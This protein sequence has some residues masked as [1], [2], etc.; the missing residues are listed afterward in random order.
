M[1]LERKEEEEM[2]E[3]VLVSSGILASTLSDQR[4]SSISNL[5]ESSLS[6]PLVSVLSTSVLFVSDRAHMEGVIGKV[7][8]R[9]EVENLPL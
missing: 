6:T 7:E 2:E 1:K 3:N 4:R 5:L 8:E 9:E